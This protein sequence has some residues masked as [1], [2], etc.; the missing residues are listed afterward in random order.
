M[1]IFRDDGEAIVVRYTPGLFS[2]TFRATRALK[3][4][5]VL[6]SLMRVMARVY[7]CSKPQPETSDF[8]TELNAGFAAKTIA[9]VEFKDVVRGFSS[10]KLPQIG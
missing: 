9:T 10:L 2:Q 7:N 8:T 5:D 6:R 1:S 3:I 4:V